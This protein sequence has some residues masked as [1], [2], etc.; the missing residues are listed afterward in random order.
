MK[1]TEYIAFIFSHFAFFIVFVW[2]GALKVFGFSPAGPLVT[3]L[4]NHTLGLVLPMTADK[5]MGAFGLLEVIIGIFFIIPRMEKVAFSLL[6]PHMLTT[7]MPLVFL[8][9]MTWSSP[10]VPTLE[11][12]YIIKNVIIIALA[13][14]MF[15]DMNKKKNFAKA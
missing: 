11:G 8:P 5:F 7:I 15:A 9:E 6:I 3:N 13:A 2:F 10:L 12:Q 14:M 1:R 4:F